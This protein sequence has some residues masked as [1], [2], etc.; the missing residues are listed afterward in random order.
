[1]STLKPTI[2]GVDLIS[3][4]A[5]PSPE[6]SVGVPLFVGIAEPK[7]SFDSPIKLDLKT[8]FDRFFKEKER[9]KQKG[10]LKDVIMGFFENGGRMCYVATMSDNT[11]DDLQ[12]ALLDSEVIDDIDLICA[13]DIML[14]EQD[15]HLRMQTELLEHCK[16][17]GN[18]FAILDTCQIENENDIEQLEQQ[19]Q[20]LASSYGA[21][22]TPWLA[23]KPKQLVPPC[24]HV[25]GTYAKADQTGGVHKAPANI[26]L[27]GVI[28]LSFKL[29]PQ[30]QE[31][32]N[33][34]NEPGINCIR[35]FKGRGIRVW[36]VRTLSQLPEWQYIN[37]RRLFLTMRR[38]IDQNLANLIFEPNTFPLWI[39][40]QR[41]LSIYCEA[42]WQQGALQGS[43]PEDAFY[44][45][46]DAA[47]T[48]VDHQNIGQVVAEVG[49]APTIPGEFIKLFLTR[50]SNGFALT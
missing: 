33:P 24:G 43:I 5:Q 28:D 34:S 30:Q 14:S 37:V 50:S 1:M 11:I 36:G 44:V 8:D 31:W 47:T 26:P 48:S 41:E 21:L 38:W 20:T 27:E 22:Y 10:Y 18:R 17:M 29:T 32:L 6:L 15:S 3:V 13:P 42:L 9:E 7:G 46:C 39:R 12:K 4:V 49:L 40:L 2:P 25:A 23:I 45:K 16:H 35:S 19:R